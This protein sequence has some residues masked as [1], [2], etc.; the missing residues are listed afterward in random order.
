MPNPVSRA[1]KEQLTELHIR[2]TV[3]I[4]YCGYRV[5]RGERGF[6]ESQYGSSWTSVRGA[7]G[8]NLDVSGP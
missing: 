3:P 8:I 1:G 5:Q 7:A 2:N 4:Q 6:N